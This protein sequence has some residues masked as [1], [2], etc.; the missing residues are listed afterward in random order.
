MASTLA[1]RPLHE[2]LGTAACEAAHSLV[3]EL[4][5]GPW[6]GHFSSDILRST[7]NPPLILCRKQNLS[8]Q[9]EL[10]WIPVC[11]CASKINIPPCS[12]QPSVVV[13]ATVLHY[14]IYTLGI[15]SKPL[16]MVIYGAFH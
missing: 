15:L 1:V 8:V 13:E 16:I 4:S 10:E 11:V 12:M 6:G 5:V 14:L 3:K 9:T 2:L 7:Q